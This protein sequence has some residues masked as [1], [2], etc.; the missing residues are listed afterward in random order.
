MLKKKPGYVSVHIYLTIEE[1][2]TLKAMKGSKT[3]D[4]YI[5]ELAGLPQNN[6]SFTTKGSRRK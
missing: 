2:G 4:Q 3:W 6:H 1:H 5:L